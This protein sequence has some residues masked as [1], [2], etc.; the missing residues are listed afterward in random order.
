MHNED[1][2]N[3][4]DSKNPHY[5]ICYRDYVERLAFA[6]DNGCN[7]V[8][9]TGT[10]EPQQNMTFLR[11]FGT[12]NKALTSPFRWVEI[13][14]TGVLMDRNM[15]RFLRNH[16]GV[17]TLSLSMSSFDWKKN[18]EYNGTPEN[19]AIKLVE[20]SDMVK[21]YGYNLRLSLNMTDDFEK[22]GVEAIFRNI[23]IMKAD[24]VTFRKL[25][26]KKGSEQ[27][28]WVDAHA[29]SDDFLMQIEKH[30]RKNGELIGILEYG[31]EQW[32]YDGVSYVFDNDCMAKEVKATLKYLVLRP[33]A[34]LYSSWDNKA[35]LL[36]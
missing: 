12:M 27:E 13:Q 21:E 35:S 4:L 25:Y 19:L 32:A 26:S 31:Q 34:R 8:M 9:L 18:M 29:C 7:T 10:A 15:L 14:T 23:K 30:I 3:M 22:I 17:S 36:F 6:R 20:F 2:P 5:D 11:E 33:N 1:Y 28:Y 24:Q 16:V